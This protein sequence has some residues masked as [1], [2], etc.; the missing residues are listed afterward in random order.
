MSFF[1]L[2]HSD[3]NTITNI[4]NVKREIIDSDPRL[5]M[6]NCSNDCGRGFQEKCNLC[7]MLYCKYCLRVYKRKFVCSGCYS[8]EKV[9][10]EFLKS[11]DKDIWKAI[12]KIFIS[13]IGCC[14]VVMISS[15]IL[16]IISVFLNEFLGTSISVIIMGAFLLLIILG[17]I[18]ILSKFKQYRES[19]RRTFFELHNIYRIN[20]R[21]FVHCKGYEFKILGFLFK[22]YFPCNGH[23]TNNFYPYKFIEK[24]SK[25]EKRR[26]KKSETRNNGYQINSDGSTI[27]SYN[28][29]RG[30]NKFEFSYSNSN[31]ISSTSEGNEFNMKKSDSNQIYV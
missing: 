29:T 23:G 1:N 18:F 17:F 7:Q 28:G 25:E 12:F 15:I 27:D 26:N 9:H 3:K 16:P 5:Y 21:V 31:K 2:S 8:V 14:C 20:W 30:E 24:V 4:Q 19:R 6:D 22:S 10:D 11:R 13:C